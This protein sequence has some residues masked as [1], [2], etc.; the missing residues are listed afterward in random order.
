MAARSEATTLSLDRYT[1][2]AKALVASAHCELSGDT[3]NPPPSVT[4]LYGERL[5]GA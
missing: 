5:V 4:G 3:N 1:P 2:E